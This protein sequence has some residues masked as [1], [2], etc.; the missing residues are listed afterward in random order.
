[1][2][3]EV[4]A[5]HPLP[6]AGA[7]LIGRGK[8][9]DVVLADGL[10]SRQ[11]A[12][13]HIGSQGLAIE[14]LGSAN[15]TRLRER[16]LPQGQPTPLLPG[17]AIGIGT[18]LL[19]VTHDRSPVTRRHL[20]SHE[21]FEGR[22][23]WECARAEADRGVFS[24]LRLRAE[25]RPELA[26]VATA[27]E[28]VLRPLDLLGSY[29]PDHY[30][31]L[32]LGLSP[33]PASALA[34]AL[35]SCLQS[36]GIQARFGL[37]SYPRDGR[38]AGALLAA[39]APGPGTRAE[40]EEPGIK[41]A[42]EAP[43]MQRV[44]ALAERAA[45]GTINVL[46]LGETGA[47]KEVLARWIHQASAR[48]NRPFVCVDCAALSPS[49]LESELFGHE[50]GAFTGAGPA[51]AGLLETAPG[52]TVFLDEIGE[53][54]LPLQAKLL[55]AIENREITRVGGVR[56]RSIDVRFLAAT[57]RDLEA[58][59]AAGSFRRDLYYRMNG[60]T[61]LLPPLRERVQDI[62]A[63]ARGFVATSCRAN[64]RRP[65]TIS[66]DAL[67]LLRGH[68]WPGNIRELRNVIERA[69]LLCTG[70]ELTSAHLAETALTQPKI[71]VAPE[72]VPHP[73]NERERIVT[74][75]AECAGNQSRAAR[76]LGLSR[77]RLIARLEAYGLARPKKGTPP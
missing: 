1:M 12:R 71:V 75:L 64:R 40:A 20:L 54:P 24:L 4:F 18:T 34:H 30:Q 46:V 28:R 69:L 61:L 25:G 66:A 10:A 13:L 60:M 47:G 74:A 65:P 32:L 23:E 72:M 53:L 63:L 76:K 52:G 19:M 22:V 73:I 11:H 27:A 3:P 50:R 16:K 2:A 42:S 43:A 38:H 57:N 48:A 31:V 49:L 58:A 26:A 44:L 77:K 45:A 39:A 29:A 14:D 9:A 41:L 68:S 35:V 7:L 17:E 8:G 62:A 6:A 56:A 59:V 5:S 70:D 36:A 37:S 21:E 67:A 51:K 15:G 33:E 55:R